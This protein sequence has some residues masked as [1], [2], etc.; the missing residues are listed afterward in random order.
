MVNQS[1]K[2]KKKILDS[3]K[4][5]FSL[6]KSTTLQYCR[7]LIKVLL[8]VGG[9]I[10]L[11]FLLSFLFQ[12]FGELNQIKLSTDMQDGIKECDQTVEYESDSVFTLLMLSDF[13]DDD[14]LTLDGASLIQLDYNSPE[15]R[16][17]SFHPGI[18]FGP[19]S[20]EEV[21]TNS[22]GV[23]LVR[24]RDLMMVGHLQN[25]PVPLAYAFYQIREFLAIPVDG[26]LYIDGDAN[27]VSGLGIG[28]PP[29]E[30]VSGTKEYG[31]WSTEWNKYWID[32]LDSVSLLKI[33]AHR[34]DIPK[35]ES[36]MSAVELYEFISAFQDVSS[37][38]IHSITLSQEN[39][40]EVVDESGETVNFLSEFAVD[41]VLKEFVG[42]V[43][44]D[45]EQARIE[46]F[47]GSG[48][49][50]LGSRY[51]RWI[52][53]IGGDVIRVENAPGVWDRSVIYVTDLDEFEYT[54]A[55]VLSLWVEDVDIVEGRPDFVTTGDVIVVLGREE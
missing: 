44:M 53:H 15:I 7:L 24:I 11:F 33:W 20:F 3:R 9:L 17:I 55:K 10:A 6:N 48:V 28:Y 26:Y 18:Y 37:E 32:N 34:M 5:S 39:L 14:R 29:S 47:N 43:R 16:I 38:N 54:V 51:S 19:Y 50:G 30:A 36:N 45:R 49:N 2:L 27:E 25:P 13:G 35:I 12:Q 40:V 21:L 4:R 52:D 46:I 8:L 23:T 31:Q 41:E 1:F 22:Y 42:D